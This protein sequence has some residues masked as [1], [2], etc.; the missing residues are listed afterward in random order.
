ML[1][2]MLRP[3]FLAR[4][5]SRRM[6]CQKGSWE[7]LVYDSERRCFKEHAGAIGHVGPFF[8]PRCKLS[9]P[10]RTARTH[11]HDFPPLFPTSILKNLSVFYLNSPFSHK[12]SPC[13]FGA[14]HEKDLTIYLWIYTQYEM[15]SNVYYEN[16]L[17][18]KKSL[19]Q[20]LN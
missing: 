10:S 12:T 6:S 1:S 16:A 19:Q 17:H 2:Y 13:V 14:N 20:L 4:K 9:T 8:M 18:E 7:G 5:A 11:L 3:P 15:P